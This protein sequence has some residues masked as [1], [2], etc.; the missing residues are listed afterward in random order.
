[1]ASA[2]SDMSVEDTAAPTADVL[3]LP[4]EAS[5][6]MEANPTD[7]TATISSAKIPG[8][9]V[10]AAVAL[11]EEK[12]SQIAMEGLL[13]FA[14]TSGNAT[15]LDIAA[16][17]DAQ[18][19][20]STALETVPQQPAEGTLATQQD[21][22]PPTFPDPELPG[23]KADAPT[24]L[25]AA[26]STSLIPDATVVKEEVATLPSLSST[27]IVVDEATE[28]AAAPSD[29]VI[30][31]SAPI[32]S[33]IAPQSVEQP[34]PAVSNV[35]P[36]LEHVQVKQEAQSAS[37]LPNVTENTVAKQAAASLLN[38]KPQTLTR[39]AKLKQR[40]DKDR[41]DGEAWSELIIDA[42]QKGDLERTR[43]VYEGFL[44]AFPDNVGRFLFLHSLRFPVKPLCTISD[45]EQS[46][47]EL[48]SNLMFSTLCIDVPIAMNRLQNGLRT[49]SWSYHTAT[50]PKSIRS[51]VDVCALRRPSGFGTST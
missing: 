3:P 41:F 44:K 25:P 17:E 39:L 49:P 9:D 2:D 29:E 19:T 48:F 36:P 8:F 12:E 13:A 14:D 50:T 7:E 28:A 46:Y 21:R 10:D 20:P 18:A 26:D 37:A 45:V 40:V 34:L 22:S 35:V 38:R 33:E 43:D 23:L 24:T 11:E 6:A 32:F 47:M 30:L 5:A 15:G 1:M 16:D 4:T 51:S 31:N 42:L 27:D